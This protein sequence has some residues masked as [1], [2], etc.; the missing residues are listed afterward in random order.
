MKTLQESLKDFKTS[1]E[2]NLKNVKPRD[3]YVVLV[4]AVFNSY[5]LFISCLY[6]VHC[7]SHEKCVFDGTKTSMGMYSISY[8]LIVND[9]GLHYVIRMKFH[10]RL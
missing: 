4:A 2:E 8:H 3:Q 7:H 5:I 6:H 1:L 9:H 10:F